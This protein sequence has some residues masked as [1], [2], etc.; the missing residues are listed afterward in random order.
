MSCVG[1]VLGNRAPL[2]VCGEKSFVL[3][4]AW[5]IWVFHGI[6]FSQQLNQFLPLKILPG[7]KRWAVEIFISLITGSLH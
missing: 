4:T 6:S 5:D 2:S 3:A 7:D 1:V